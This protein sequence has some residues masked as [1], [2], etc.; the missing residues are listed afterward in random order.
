MTGKD[1]VLFLINN[2]LLDKEL[3][4]KVSDLFLSTSEAAVKLGISTTS[5]DDMVKLGIINHIKIDGV[6]YVS[7]H[8]DLKQLKRRG[9]E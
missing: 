6:T 1:L 5:M 9:Y 7:D 3:G 4:P 2:D 8:I